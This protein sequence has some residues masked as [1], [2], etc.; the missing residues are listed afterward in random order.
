MRKQRRGSPAGRR[1]RKGTELAGAE[2]CPVCLVPSRSLIILPCWACRDHSVHGT[3]SSTP[4]RT[5]PPIHFGEYFILPLKDKFWRWEATFSVATLLLLFLFFPGA[6]SIN[7][8]VAQLRRGARGAASFPAAA[9]KGEGASP[10][11]EGRLIGG[12]TPN[13]KAAAG[14]FS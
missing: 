14:R 11:P 13:A 9:T 12:K 1:S 4:L 2:C 10:N 7:H 3:L 6:E 5:S 8:S